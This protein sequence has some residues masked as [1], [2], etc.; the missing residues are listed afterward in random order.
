MTYRVQMLT[1]DGEHVAEVVDGRGYVWARC[2]DLCSADKVADAL[3]LRDDLLIHDEDADADAAAWAAERAGR[4]LA[5]RGGEDTHGGR[6]VRTVA[7]AE[8]T[9]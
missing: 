3:S 4:D 6:R 1:S 7:V 5:A 8:G 9:L 2:L